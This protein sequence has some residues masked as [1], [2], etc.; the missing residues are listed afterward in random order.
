MSRYPHRKYARFPLV[1]RRRAAAW[2]LNHDAW[3]WALVAV[4]LLAF[5]ALEWLRVQP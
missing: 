5:V 3:A 2:R 4:T 1:R